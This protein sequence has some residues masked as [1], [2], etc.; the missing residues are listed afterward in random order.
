MMQVN[1][2]RRPAP[3]PIHVVALERYFQRTQG[4]GEAAPA[5]TTFGEFLVHEGVLDRFQLFR[6]LQLQ[7][8]APNLRIGEC[9]VKLGFAAHGAIERMFER[10][11]HR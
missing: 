1:F 6:A 10:Y 7:D 3:T 9:A 8:R 5:G 11:A 4:E 2:S